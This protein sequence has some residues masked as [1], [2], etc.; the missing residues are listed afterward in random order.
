MIWVL[1]NIIHADSNGEPC[2]VWL[3]GYSGHTTARVRRVARQLNIEIVLI[4]DGGTGRGQPNDLRLNGVLKSTG[5]RL[6]KAK[7]VGMVLAHTLVRPTLMDGIRSYK[8][9]ASQ[10]TKRAVL[11][12]WELARIVP[13]NKHPEMAVHL[14]TTPPQQAAVQPQRTRGRKARR[15]SRPDAR[16]LQLAS[17]NIMWIEPHLKLR[18]WYMLASMGV[19]SDAHI[20]AVSVLLLD[21]H[22]TLHRGCLQ[23]ILK[24]DLEAA[25]ALQNIGRLSDSLQFHHDGS[26]HWLLSAC[27]GRKVY[28][29][30]SL[31]STR[32]KPY[33]KRQLWTLYDHGSERSFEVQLLP[34]QRQKGGIQCGDFAI[35]FAAFLAVLITTA[36]REVAD[37]QMVCS[38]RLSLDQD[39]MR[40]H[41]L[42]C[43]SSGRI[44][45]FPTL[46][47]DQPSLEVA[48]TSVTIK[49]P[50][51]RRKAKGKGKGKGKA[52]KAKG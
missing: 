37:I 27:V 1:R 31:F 21:Q 10:I 22:P 2:A 50:Q 25:N 38:H 39:S 34:V 14:L 45:S 43:F 47:P 26:F 52:A 12:G 16:D 44:S 35:A 8:Q 42:D 49:K 32:I 7:Y 41:L 33:V 29:L 30:D 48:F 46:Q 20:H 23:D 19:L 15:L 6:W 51:A 3:D 17:S 11:S 4:P 24:A 13:S 36:Q 40:R 18:H 28:V 9:A 5:R